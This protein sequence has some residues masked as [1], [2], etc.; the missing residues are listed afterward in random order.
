MLTPPESIDLAECLESRRLGWWHCKI[1][2]LCFVA[3][4]VEG[5]D[6]NALAVGV[7]AIVR[8]WGVSQS[9][10]GIAFGLG[11][12]GILIGTLL[13]SKIGDRFGRRPGIVASVFLYSIL[14]LATVVA[15]S[16]WELALLRFL[17]GVGMGGVIPNAIALL[18]EVSPARY[19]ARFVIIPF[20]GIGLG[21]A[22]IG[23]VAAAF[24]PRFGWE[25]VFAIPG[26]AGLVVGLALLLW[27]PE[28]IHF[29]ALRRPRSPTL[30][31]MERSLV[32]ELGIDPRTQFVARRQERAAVGMAPLL[33][34]RNRLITP[35]I[36]TCFFFES[37]T[38]VILVSWL[39]LLLES[40]GLTPTQ[41]SLT[42]A[43]VGIANIFSQFAM[44]LCLERFD[45]RAPF[46]ASLITIGC[47]VLFGLPWGGPQALVLVTIL[48]VASAGGTHSSFNG[49]V[50]LFYPT[51]IRVTGVGIA[52]GFGRIAFIVGPIAAGYLIAYAPDFQTLTL[53][54]A[55]PYLPVALACWILARV[56]AGRAGGAREEA[57]GR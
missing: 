6:Y 10:I 32:A 48:L 30:L 54:I 52:A 14:A 7:P 55:L 11:N 2:L 29:L 1:A 3:L 23:G 26:A 37:L 16:I 21:V 33:Q 35:L 56:Y 25:A 9:D 31:R 19:K 38:F 43:S 57:L 8:T 53:T 39:P 17:A 4:L 15:S 22:A 42:F 18:T 47:F 41:A 13:F 51:D 46:V 45:F 5:M 34:G 27:L 24:I 40:A 50:G 28:S 12:L 36:W 49:L 44:A 20:I